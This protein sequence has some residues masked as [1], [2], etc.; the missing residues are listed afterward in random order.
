MMTLRRRR[1]Q[2]TGAHGQRGFTLLEVMVALAITTAIAAMAYQG[3]VSASGGAERSREIM[4]SINEMDRAWQIIAA[5]FRHIL[6]PQQTATGELRFRFNS[7]SMAGAGNEQRILLFSR[8]AWFNPMNRLRSDLQEVSYRLEEDQLW[9]D[10]R[11]IRNRPFDEFDFEEQALNQ[12]LLSGVEDIEIRFLSRQLITRSGA[13]A[14]EGDDFTRDWA[15]GWPDPNVMD[16]SGQ[17]DLPLA[18]WVRIEV[19]GVGVSER[20]FEITGF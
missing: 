18:V 7:E 8:H 19:E 16:G 13:G 15:P 2:K 9:R 11:P 10:Y 14:L 12:R 6:P 17:T 3:L 5:D 20:L 1:K 4:S